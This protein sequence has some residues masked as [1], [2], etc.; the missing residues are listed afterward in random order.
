VNGVA[1]GH[2]ENPLVSSQTNFA[3]PVLQTTPSL[4]IIQ[5]KEKKSLNTP[6]LKIALPLTDAVS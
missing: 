6:Y 1:N 5:Y 4:R 3:L 2:G